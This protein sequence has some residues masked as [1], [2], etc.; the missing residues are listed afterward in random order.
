MESDNIFN[1]E[2]TIYYRTKE[3]LSK[4][5]DAKLYNEYK[6]L[7]EEYKQFLD[8]MGVIFSVSDNNHKMNKELH[9]KL[10][11]EIEQKRQ[12]VF[13]LKDEMQ[14]LSEELIRINNLKEEFLASTSQELKFPINNIISSAESIV[15]QGSSFLDENL[16][17]ELSSI[18]KTGKAI[19]YMVNDL[20][21]YSK[22]KHKD[23][24]L[25]KEEYELN[26]LI[27]SIIKF[28][29]HLVTD[30]SIIFNNNIKKDQFKIMVDK[31]RFIQILYDILNNICKNINQVEII[32][33]ALLS[34]GQVQ[35]KI[36]VKPLSYKNKDID[37]FDFFAYNN[38]IGYSITKYL[39]KLHEADMSVKKEK[40]K[41]ILL[42]SFPGEKCQD[43]YKSLSEKQLSKGEIVHNK[44][45]KGKDNLEKKSIFIVSNMKKDIKFIREILEKDNYSV[46]GVT[47]GEEALKTV[48]NNF[49]LVIMD[50]F[51]VDINSIELCQRIREHYSSLELPILVITSRNN[52]QNFIMGYGVGVNDFIKKPFEISELKARI[53]TL[54]NLKESVDEAFTYKYDLWRAQIK[55]H[56]LYN[57]IDTIAVLCEDTP[58]I[59]KKLILDLG[60]YLRYSFDFE[61]LSNFISIKEELKIVRIYVNIQQI[62]FKDKLRVVFNLEDGLDFAIPPLIIQPLVENAIKYGVLEKK[63]GGTVEINISK[64]EKQIIIAVKD[65]GPGMD[66]TIIAAVMS[67]KKNDRLGTGLTNV[68]R[69]VKKIYDTQ[70]QIESVKDKGTSVIIKIPI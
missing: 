43:L 50:L 46:T 27:N 31:S 62:R 18:I 53:K 8:E 44:K 58:E 19:D 23:I 29:E 33:T 12:T 28:Y 45:V 40:N 9:L 61:G 65:D 1:R 66:E 11:E 35:I 57:T 67:G 69:R 38:N 13:K 34:N 32:F 10:E 39:V 4:N 36:S 59:A 55:P 24:Q 52:P 22:I 68:N 17:K 54:I 21:D 47:S 2:H 16:K 70:L 26:D 15:R 42:M 64:I 3:V 56:F 49:S 6:S 5:K 30:K 7:A 14:K 60:Q 48:D 51:L 25:N 63:D 37:S 20:V 41:S